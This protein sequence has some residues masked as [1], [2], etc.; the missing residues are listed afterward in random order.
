MLRKKSF[1]FVLLLTAMLMLSGCAGFA[2]T[3]PGGAGNTTPA[4]V[5]L[6][7]LVGD[8]TFPNYV[9]SEVRFNLTSDDFTIMRTVTAEASSSSVLGLFS[10]GDNGYGKLWEEAFKIGADD[11]INIKVDNRLRRYVIA[12]YAES[13]VKLTGLAIKY[14]NKQK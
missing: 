3:H 10:F 7:T 14:N 11:V 13:T 2:I 1:V 9:G 5:N 4:G 12:L 8:V 6:G